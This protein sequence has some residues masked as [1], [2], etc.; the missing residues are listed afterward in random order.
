MSINQQSSKKPFL[1]IRK[2]LFPYQKVVKKRQILAFPSRHL[3]RSVLVDFYL[4]PRYQY[5]FNHSYPVLI[6]NDGQDLEAV[7]LQATLERL[8]QEH[9]IREILVVG[10]HA[11]EERMQ[12]YGTAKYSDYKSRGSKAQAHTDFILQEL[13][14]FLNRRYRVKSEYAI[15]GFSLGGLSAFDIAWNHPETFQKVGV[16]SGSLWWRSKAMEPSDPDADRIAHH[17]VRV[18]PKKDGLRFWFQ[19]G[20]RD[21]TDD[22][23][24]NGII[25][26]IDDTRDLIAALEQIGY[27]EGENIQYVEVV[28][29][30]HNPQTWGDILPDFLEWGFS[31]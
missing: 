28:D 17:M 13:L 19:T 8:Y 15:A 12:E 31:K 9:R 18:G 20:T 5:R 4:P 16:F 14:P 29:G 10:I 21:E 30:E 7:R 11:N 24:N 2:F 22:R 3:K 27:Q 1:G 23:N 26:S 6:F 25:D